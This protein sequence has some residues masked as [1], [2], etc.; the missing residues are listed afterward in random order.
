MRDRALWVGCL[1]Y[2]ALFTGLG[3]LKYLVHRNLVDFGIFA[4]TAASAFGCFC[5]P[6]EGSHW[7]FHFSPILYAVG[8]V[9]TAARSSIALI[10]LQAVAGA[11]VA[12]PLYALALRHSNS[13][14]VARGTAL[15]AWLYP[16]LAGLIFGDF[17]ENGF[18]PAAVAWLLYAF[19][20]GRAGWTLLAACVVLTIKED[21]A[22]FLTVGGL[23]GAW[24]F[25]GTPRGR[26]AGTIAI[27]SAAVIV[28]FFAVIAPHA[29]AATNGGW[30]PERFYAWRAADARDLFGAVGARLGFLLLVLTPLIF[31]PLRSR[32]FWLA[33]APLC[34]VLFSRL[35]TTFTL[36]THYAGAWIGYVLVAYACAMPA[37]EPRR[38]R[39]AIV[40]CVVLCCAEFVV[41]NPLHPAL[42]LR[43]VQPRDV[44]LDRFL[45]R[46]PAGQDVAT[47]EEAYTHLALRDSRATLLPES[48]QIPEAACYVLVDR[49][50]PDSPRLQE[51]GA[52]LR[53]LV[54]NGRYGVAL[55]Q[56]PIVL[57]RRTQRCR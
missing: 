46:L 22:A 25:R 41:A 11:L 17:H 1:A 5:N 13:I 9:M 30:Q 38:A 26:I 23:L 53:E 31:L 55:R 6:I 18:A 56:G 42:N 51:Y 15:V 3:A 54:R 2:A 48:P 45:A 34:E 28:L 36:G 50:F 24:H 21:Q 33:L 52:A 19:D 27:L 8:A 57:Y 49:D 14:T 20:A 29:A 37:L 7:A 16:P 44:N 47:Q 39:R 35:P 43:A 12:P 32:Y 4:Q 10:A 40:A